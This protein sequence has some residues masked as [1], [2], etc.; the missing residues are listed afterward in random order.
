MRFGVYLPTFAFWVAAG[1]QDPVLAMC[2]YDL[3]QLEC[4]ATDIA[5][6]FGRRP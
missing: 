4:F 2:D 3:E 6:R 1:I 5:G